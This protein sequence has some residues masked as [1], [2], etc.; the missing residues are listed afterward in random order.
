MKKNDSIFDS[1]EPVNDALKVSPYPRFPWES[2]KNE[3]WKSSLEW[4]LN[5]RSGNHFAYIPARFLVFP[6]MVVLRESSAQVESWYILIIGTIKETLKENTCD[7]WLAVDYHR[8]WHCDLISSLLEN[9]VPR[10]LLHSV[11][12]QSLISQ[13]C[14]WDEHRM[15]PEIRTRF[16]P[17]C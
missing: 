9:E 4:Y 2:A 8:V 14:N 12:K 10:Q 17:N 11:S 3:D 7:W 16:S 5:D 1:I 6:W 13:F 15:Y